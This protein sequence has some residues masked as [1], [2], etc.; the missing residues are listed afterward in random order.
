VNEERPIVDWVRSTGT[1]TVGTAFTVAPEAGDTYVITSKYRWDEVTSA[2]NMAIDRATTYGALINITDVTTLLIASTYE[3]AMPSNFTHLF[4]VT[5][6]DGNGQYNDPV[7]SN[8]WSIVRGTSPI[9]RLER[10]PVEHMLTDIPYGAFW[11]DSSITAGRT[12]RLEGFKKQE[13]LTANADICYL[14][15]E[16][17]CNQTAAYLNAK[18]IRR[19]D[20][21]VDNYAAQYQMRQAEA[22]SILVRMKPQFPPDTRRV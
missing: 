4:R 6:L 18:R 11:A 16:Y 3:Y 14:D 19:N 22:N 2:V 17:I 7:P 20:V 13:H 10:Y 9:L 12:L 15:P 5:M 1:A 21:D 8:Q